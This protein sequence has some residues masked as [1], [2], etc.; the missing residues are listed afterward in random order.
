[1]EIHYDYQEVREQ[2]I[3]TPRAVRRAK[4]MAMVRLFGKA[5]RSHSL[6]TANDDTVTLIDF[7]FT[8]LEK[9]LLEELMELTTK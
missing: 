6:T 4:A 7:G 5:T 2:P 8:L 3:R 1:M 9:E